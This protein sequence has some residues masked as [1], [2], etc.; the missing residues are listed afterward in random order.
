M[1]RSNVGGAFRL[2]AGGKRVAFQV[3]WQDGSPQKLGVDMSGDFADIREL[4]SRMWLAT[5]SS[6]KEGMEWKL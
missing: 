5:G 6:L 4:S 1:E 3:K 2:S